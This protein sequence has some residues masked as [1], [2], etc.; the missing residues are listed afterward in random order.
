MAVL[1]KISITAW[2]CSLAAYDAR[3]QLLTA[4]ANSIGR[5]SYIRTK[6]AAEVCKLITTITAKETQTQCTN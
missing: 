4:T 2:Y 6:S 5:Q 1:T 3:V